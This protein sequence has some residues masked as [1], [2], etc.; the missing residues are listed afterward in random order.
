MNTDL[1]ARMTNWHMRRMQRVALGV[2]PYESR[3]GGFSLEKM[4]SQVLLGKVEAHL[5]SMLVPYAVLLAAN[6]D[7]S[8]RDQ[9]EDLREWLDADVWQNVDARLVMLTK[10][11]PSVRH[12]VTTLMS[13]AVHELGLTPLEGMQWT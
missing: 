2:K 11:D 10:L 1:E 13:T 6:L 9:D 3:L 7:F 5:G 8:G 12:N 4:L